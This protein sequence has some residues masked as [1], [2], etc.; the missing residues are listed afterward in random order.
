[1]KQ[2]FYR[3]LFLLIFL[4][5]CLLILPVQQWFSPRGDSSNNPMLDHTVSTQVYP[6]TGADS[7][8]FNINSARFPIRLLTNASLP[9]EALHTSQV[10]HF[11]SSK[12]ELKE[13]D[14][15]Y[16]TELGGTA[17]QKKQGE[18]Q[19]R[20]GIKLLLLDEQGKKLYQKTYHLKSGQKQHTH[21]LENRV[22]TGPLNFYPTDKVQVLDTRSVLFNPPKEIS[23]LAD[24][25]QVSLYQTDKALTEVAI[26][27]YE[28]LLL[29]DKQVTYRWQRLS[30]KQK[31]RLVEDN[32]YP[33]TFVSSDEK[34]RLLG[35]KQQ[36]MGPMGVLGE[37]YQQKKMY[38]GTEVE[39]I[40]RLLP[41][42]RA[43]DLGPDHFKV[44]YITEP[45]T[46]FIWQGKPSPKHF[47]NM[48]STAGE[49]IE[50]SSHKAIEISAHWF[51]RSA[52]QQ[53]LLSSSIQTAPPVF[54]PGLLVL[55]SKDAL[56]LTAN[57]IENG[58][59]QAAEHSVKV[60]A[61][62]DSPQAQGP[63]YHIPRASEQFAPIRIDL[64]QASPKGLATE[65]VQ[66][67][68]HNEKGHV[69]Q[70]VTLAVSDQPN[71]FDYIKAGTHYRLSERSRSFYLLP[72]EGVSLSFSST[73][74]VLINLSTR[75]LAMEK[76]THVPEDYW[77]YQG[78]NRIPTW[79]R[80][81]PEN[82]A[83]LGDRQQILVSQRRPPDRSKEEPVY[84]QSLLPAFQTAGR[85][86]LM[87]KESDQEVESDRLTQ[88]VKPSGLSHHFQLLPL[89][90][91]R[92]LDLQHDYRQRF[93]PRLLILTENDQKHTVRLFIDNR[94]IAEVSPLQSIE[95]ISL[96][97]LSPGRYRVR[98]ES[99]IF[100]ERSSEERSSGE[101]NPGV[102][103]MISHSLPDDLSDQRFL[104]RWVTPVAKT[105]RIAMA[106][107]DVTAPLVFNYDKSKVEELILLQ[108]FSDKSAFTPRVKS[109]TS[110][111]AEAELKK[112]ELPIKVSIRPAPAFTEL[113]Q[114]IPNQAISGQS[115]SLSGQ[116]ND[117]QRNRW[118]RSLEDW[119]HL[120]QTFYITAQ[121][122]SQ[123]IDLA[124]HSRNV[125]AGSPAYIR[126]GDDMPVGRYQIHISSQSQ[127]P[128]YIQLLQKHI[129]ERLNESS[130]ATEAER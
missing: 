28:R 105:S 18:F 97:E 4:I 62:S 122:T 66:M 76:V 16:M 92:V 115:G 112:I 10:Q 85:Y 42:Y 1:M 31:D 77:I 39:R 102:R 55:S 123:G 71:L 12:G 20:Y 38:V 101:R 35:F 106:G 53:I 93:S 56:A 65:T 117:L 51:G 50:K 24:R 121:P 86:L 13:A 14:L 104:K 125:V 63:R 130:Y 69:I 47:T 64:W 87:P 94:L 107:Q 75:P 45:D 116:S 15:S 37:D 46:P 61:L 127:W 5:G 54:Q 27:S 114:A 73:A 58:A 30:L 84:W 90:Q 124:S 98:L 96:P 82:E 126:L 29:T 91:E 40:P 11:D 120:E 68:I 108:V 118:G 72:P 57:N 83:E 44:F 111:G 113:E 34:Q 74:Q 8:I 26:R 48:A 36:P 49:G 95:S 110:T 80:I 119:S 79:F 52:E 25:L 43:P 19:W 3:W 21:R 32:I 9:P 129:G 99:S 17:A 2:A 70:Q 59:V 81:K 67:S 60:Y 23:A 7:L 128:I 109:L 6:L 88:P 78:N 41:E 89:N 22:L 33:T 103:G 100:G